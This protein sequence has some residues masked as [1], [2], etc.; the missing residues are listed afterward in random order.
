VLGS[1]V[2]A[3]EACRDAALALNMPFISGKDSLNNE[4]HAG[5]VHLVIPPTLLISALGRVPDVRRCVTMDLK[6]PGNPLFLIGVTRDELGGSHFHLV[7]GLT[8]GRV[9]HVDLE[10]APRLFRALHAAIAQ[11][12]V[13]SCHDLSEGGLAV[14]AA[15]MAFA[16]G[17][18]LDLTTI[19]TGPEDYPDAVWLFS[20]STTRFL[21]EVQSAQEQAF[22]ACLGDVPHTRVGATCKEPRLRIAGANG[23]WVVWA[24]L[25]DLKAAWQASLHA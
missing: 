6:E 12:L 13:R 21:V 15:E 19:R 22:R 24:A 17:V 14:A 20:E 10:R 1:L 25:T 2:R 11:G 18:G 16:G 9:P 4:F 5:D 3:A 23:E 7:H 8:G